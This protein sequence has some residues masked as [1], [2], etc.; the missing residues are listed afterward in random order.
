MRAILAII[1]LFSGT[2]AFAQQAPTPTSSP[3]IG[4]APAV[5]ASALATKV[6]KAAPGNLYSAYASNLTATAGFLQIFNA[7][8][9]PADG[10][11]V[12]QI[13]VPLP[14]SGGVSVNFS[15]GPPQVFTTGITAVVSSAST[16]FTKTT[17]TIT[18]FISGSAP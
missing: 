2:A 12:P 9:A 13:C 6:I 5:T 16:C 10:A 7:T 18:A 15:P 8:S 11:V 4:I 17:G 3:V 14:A 1:L